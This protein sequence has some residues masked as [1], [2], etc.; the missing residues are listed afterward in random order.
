[1]YIAVSIYLAVYMLVL[2]AALSFFL[3]CEGI[4]VYRNGRVDRLVTLVR[5]RDDADDTE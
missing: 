1:M 5:L 4:T 3:V 2:V